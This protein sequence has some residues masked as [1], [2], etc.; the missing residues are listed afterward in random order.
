[1]LDPWTI[2]P[3]PSG[4]AAPRRRWHLLWTTVG[5]WLLG[6]WAPVVVAAQIGEGQRQGALLI[7]LASL[8]VAALL[9]LAPSW[10]VRAV[11][12]P[13]LAVAAAAGSLGSL[14]VVAALVAVAGV[15]VA[16]A[17]LCG[18][19]LVP[20]RGPLARTRPTPAL[21][22]V[23][24]VALHGAAWRHSPSTL[25]AVAILGI[26]A[27]LLVAD[28]MRPGLLV[29]AD[30]WIARAGVKVGTAVAG[31][32]M[33]VAAVPTLWLPGLVAAP[34]VKLVERSR[35]RQT[36]WGAREAEVQDHRRDA[37]YPFASAE[38]RSRHR[39]AAFGLTL[40]AVLVAG[41]VVAIRSGPPTVVTKEVAP[42]SASLTTP[43]GNAPEQPPVDPSDAKTY[44]QLQAGKGLDWA[45]EVQ[46]EQLALPLP[47]GPVAGYDL[48]P[49]RTRYTNVADGERRTLA[50]AP[51]QCRSL[52]VWL[53]GGSVAFGVGQRDDHTIASELVRLGDQAGLSLRV[54]N[55]AVPG[56]TLWQENQKVL[57]RLAAT[58]KR[59][60][61][62][63]FYDGLNDAVQSFVQTV[64]SGPRWDQ[65]VVY[66]PQALKD[67]AAL[68]AEK[69]PARVQ[70][71]G[72]A[73][74]IGTRAGAR[75]D[76]LRRLVQAQLTAEGLPASFYFQPDATV[77]DVQRRS[78][79]EADDRLSSLVGLLSDAIGAT[80]ARASGSGT[81][82]R[83]V[84]D[85]NPD[86]LFFDLGHTNEVGAAIVARALFDDLRP[87]L[88]EINAP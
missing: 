54:R 56:Y 25:V 88:D 21:A 41:L 81:D 64:V 78:G 18:W 20:G 66:D 7:A 57:A 38:A 60:D 80:A 3:A 61:L 55:L 77:T 13:V 30:G 39:Q 36:T 44:S 79:F 5:A 2:A 42:G 43:D 26:A 72:G 33:F 62:I 75:Y 83:S 84:F 22:V 35:T 50:P 4:S 9:T 63:I 6:C 11:G 34:L 52:E 45:D 67:L 69:V 46:R 49:Y 68:G 31:A 82:L 10:W 15:T 71:E 19:G 59:P 24:V 1:M 86:P 51:C 28:R 74:A 17:A 37:G 70:D 47:P 73:A 53:V 58:R 85:G 23:P 48:G 76:T 16:S 27:A 40:A 29:P 32:V 12:V 8:A 65:P 87:T 14:G